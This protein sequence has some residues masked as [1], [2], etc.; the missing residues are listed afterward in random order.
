MNFS[1]L[2]SLYD[3]IR[4]DIYLGRTLPEDFTKEDQKN[5]EHLYYWYNHF[6]HSFNL[7]QA[8]STFTLNKVV[9]NFNQK[10]KNVTTPQKWATVSTF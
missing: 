2:C 9:G 1:K 3:T 6:I 10:I 4:V 8:F 7:S 5:I